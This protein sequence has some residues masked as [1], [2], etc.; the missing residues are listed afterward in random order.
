MDYSSATWE[1]KIN[2]TCGNEVNKTSTDID[3][4]QFESISKE[5]IAKTFNSN[6]GIQINSKS[7][8]Y[9]IIFKITN[10]KQLHGCPWGPVFILVS[11]KVTV[12]DIANS[13]IVY[14]ESF[15]RRGERQ[16]YSMERRIS[17]SFYAITMKLLYPEPK[18]YYK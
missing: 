14:S 16:A 6:A 11:G 1:D 12:V 15:M 5:T 10:L 9:K 18:K 8:K 17:N 13:E 2:T 3:Y 4:K 7:A